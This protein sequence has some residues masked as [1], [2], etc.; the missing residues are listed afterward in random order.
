V[1]RILAP[2]PELSPFIES[3]WF[4]GAEGAEPL[5]LRVEVFVDGRADLIFNFGAAYVR[6]VI[7]RGSAEMAHSNLDAQRLVPIRIVQRGQL[8]TTGVRF[9]LGGVGPFARAPLH[10]FTGSTPVPHDVFGEPASKLER[11]LQ[12]TLDADGQ[13][14][15]LDEFF[16]AQ[17]DLSTSWVAFESALRCAQEARGT[18]ELEALAEAAGASSRHVERLFARF[19]GIPPRALTRVLR[20]QTAL[21]A[22]M[23]DPGCSLAAVAA[24]AGYFDQSHFVRDFREMT[25]GA[26]RGYR[27]YFPPQ[28]PTDFAPNVVV[29]VQDDDPEER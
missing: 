5:D 12:R 4:V 20:F 25:G 22:L 8:R 28:G 18:A 11:A 16:L 21:R 27:G 24:E 26:P 29:F 17:L 2:A 1:Y 15:L 10:R 23:R 6:E 13:K 19:L 7:G 3:Y 14:S 9:H